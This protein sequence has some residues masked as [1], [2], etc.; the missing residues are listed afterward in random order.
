[1][2]YIC[3]EIIYAWPIQLVLVLTINALHIDH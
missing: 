3:K 2:Y 1:M